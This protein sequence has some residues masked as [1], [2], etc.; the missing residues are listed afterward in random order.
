MCP[1][2]Q[3]SPVTACR[4]HRSCQR[5]GPGAECVGALT[6]WV[7]DRGHDV[8]VSSG[9]TRSATVCRECVWR[10]GGM[11]LADQKH[12]VGVSGGST[13]SVTVCRGCV[14][15]SGGMCLGDREHDVGVSGD[16]RQC[17]GVCGG[18]E[19]GVWRIR[20]MTSVC[21]GQ[22]RRSGR[23][24]DRRPGT[25]RQCVPDGISVCPGREAECVRVCL[26]V[27]GRSSAMTSL[28]PGVRR[29]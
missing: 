8:A 19:G 17:V 25:Q 11:C 28:C 7:A 16:Q 9:S 6:Q 5:V 18:A 4:G 20:G 10:N 22:C 14:W 29:S 15:R 23:V 3:Q 2:T 26:G 27:C 13:R 12:D 24:C 21:L 1:A